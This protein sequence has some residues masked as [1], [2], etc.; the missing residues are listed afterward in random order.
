MEL[1]AIQ[2]D[3]QVIKLPRLPEGAKK[4]AT[5]VIVEGE[6]TGHTH[7][8]REGEIYELGNRLFL[9]TSVPTYID[10][11]EHEEIPLEMPGVYEIKRQREYSGQ[12]MTRLV[13][14]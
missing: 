9:Q 5:R 13:V 10:H 1:Y 2:G 8:L 6:T 11:E 14:D 12:N 4:K 7:R 3:I